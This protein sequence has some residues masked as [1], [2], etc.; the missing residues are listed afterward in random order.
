MLH[1]GTDSLGPAV[2]WTDGALISSPDYTPAR[3]I[4]PG[5][6]QTNK[7]PTSALRRTSIAYS[8]AANGQF[9]AAKNKPLPLVNKQPIKGPTWTASKP[10]V[11][12]IT[13]PNTSSSSYTKRLLTK[14]PKP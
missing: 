2:K 8:P 11:Q 12:S 14:V 3:T 10:A 7:P 5:V 9:S 1:L 4:I 13:Q 6:R